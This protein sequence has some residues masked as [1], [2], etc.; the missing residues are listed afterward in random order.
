MITKKYTKAARTK[1]IMPANLKK[2]DYK[3]FTDS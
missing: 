2:S 3:K 1:H